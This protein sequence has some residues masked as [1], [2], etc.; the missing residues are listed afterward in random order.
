[1]FKNYLF[2]FPVDF[3]DFYGRITIEN[4]DKF[5]MN[6][7]KYSTAV[8]FFTPINESY[9]KHFSITKETNNL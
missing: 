8:V 1:M 9:H 2:V 7:R 5:S 3:F 6:Y 4:T